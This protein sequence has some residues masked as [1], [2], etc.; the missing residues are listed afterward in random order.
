MSQRQR[1]LP[2][3]WFL[4]KIHQ[5]ERGTDRGTPFWF[6]RNFFLLS[7][8]PAPKVRHTPLCPVG[9]CAC[10]PCPPCRSFGAGSP[11]PLPYPTMRRTIGAGLSPLPCALAYPQ[12]TPPYPLSEVRWPV[13]QRPR[14]M[15]IPPHTPRIAPD[16]PGSIRMGSGTRSYYPDTPGASWGLPDVFSP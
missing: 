12:H 16:A 8:T 4:H 9:G 15:G 7:P 3:I 6:Q 1:G 11:V 10:P 13:G 2:W 5:C 14:G